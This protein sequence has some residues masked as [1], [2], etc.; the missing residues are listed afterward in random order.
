MQFT[1]TDIIH[2]PGT[3]MIKQGIKKKDFYKFKRNNHILAGGCGSYRTVTDSSTKV[4]IEDESGKPYCFDMKDELK[5]IYENRNFTQKFINDL[6]S[7]LD[8]KSFE[9]EPGDNL[10]N[11]LCEF[12]KN[13][14]C[15]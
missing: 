3:T 14:L 11:N 1:V 13:N 15:G 7:E 12:F 2:T 6:K 9:V 4:F 10:K 8:N 5:E